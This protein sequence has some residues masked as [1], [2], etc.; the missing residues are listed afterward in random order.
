MARLRFWGVLAAGAIS[1]PSAVIAQRTTADDLLPKVE[2]CLVDASMERASA[3]RQ[4]VI[5]GTS[6]TLAVA[7][8]EA[9]LPSDAGVPV[10]ALAEH[11]LAVDRVEATGEAAPLAAWTEPPQEAL[12]ALEVRDT[13]TGR[14]I[15]LARPAL[16]GVLT[17]I[18]AQFFMGHGAAHPQTH[19]RA[20]H[21]HLGEMR[22]LTV[23][24]L[25]LGEDWKALLAS[26]AHAAL[27]DALGDLYQA[28]APVEWMAAVSDP[29]RWRF[30]AEGLSLEFDAY[31]V[32]AYFAGPQRVFIPWARLEAS[33]AFNP[34]RGL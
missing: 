18:D 12:A 31:E 17:I 6:F 14:R 16:A 2:D 11:V 25:F 10:D 9:E 8:F 1:L 26:I 23:D 5:P 20:R 33:L 27:A 28:P 24:D 13:D 21:W 19:E 22:P 3:P 15:C 7:R 4:F 29:A 34:R 30:T 32:A